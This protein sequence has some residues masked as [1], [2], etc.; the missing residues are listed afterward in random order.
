MM[1]EQVL[2]FPISRGRPPMKRSMIAV[3]LLLLSPSRVIACFED[4]N[5]GAGWFDQQNLHWSSYGNAAQAM[6]RDKLLDVS[7]IAGGSGVVILLGVMIRAKVQSARR[8][9]DSSSEPVEVGQFAFPFDGPASEPWCV[10]PSLDFDESGWTSPE[11]QDI[12]ITPG[13]WAASA[14]DSF[15]SLS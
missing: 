9:A 10:R 12:G 13:T 4:H 11:I 7:L 6:Q 1:Y 14:A 3:C 15:C 5:A 8:A 2:S